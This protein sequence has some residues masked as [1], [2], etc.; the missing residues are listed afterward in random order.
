MLWGTDW[1]HPSHKGPALDDEDFL[2]LLALWVP[3][4]ATR[5]RI[6]VSNPEAVYGFAAEAS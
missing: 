4:R 5:E 2:R 3:E 6:L 1:P